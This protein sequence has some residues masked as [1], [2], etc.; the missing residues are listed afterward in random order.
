MKEKMLKTAENMFR[1]TAQN[2]DALYGDAYLL[3]TFQKS[4]MCSMFVTCK[5]KEKSV[6]LSTYE[7]IGRK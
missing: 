2:S 7:D 6:Y 4:F 5:V 3:S 1:M